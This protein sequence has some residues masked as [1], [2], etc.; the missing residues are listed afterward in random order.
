M[1]A[2][3]YRKVVYGVLIV[4]LWFPL[5]F[6]GEPPSV[7][8]E[9]ART[10]GKLTMLRDEYDLSQA[11]LGEIDPTSESMK[12]A[13]LGM[14]GVAIN[15]LWTMANE[16][17][18]K[19]DFDNFAATVNQITTLAPNFISVWEFQAH[20]ET[21]NVSVEYDAYRMRY[22]WVKKGIDLLIRGTEF[23]RK[24]TRLI[25]YLSWFF[26]HKIGTAD[27]KKQFRQLF[28]EDY[29]YHA[30]LNETLHMAMDDREVLGPNRKDPDNWLVSRKVQLRAVNLVETA[31]VPIRGKSPVLFYA[32]AP[33]RRINYSRAIEG[34]GW[35]GDVA[36]EAWR[37]SSEDWK[38]YGGLPIPTS[39]GHDVRLSEL[40][41]Y[42]E[43][44][45]QALEELDEIA[46]GEREKIFNERMAR[47]RTD[48]REALNTPPEKRTAQQEALAM[49]AEPKVRPSPDEVANRV[50]GEKR[51]EAK[52]LAQEAL[53]TETHAS[54]IERYRDIVNFAYWRDRCELEQMPEALAARQAMV[55]ADKALA[56][57]IIEATDTGKPGA[58]ELYETA[59]K[60]W[61]KVY[62]KYPHMTN[63]TEADEVV[64][65]IDR[66][67]SVLLQLEYRG[68][69]A[70]FPLQGL[71]EAQR[72]GTAILQAEESSANEKT[73]EETKPSEPNGSPETKDEPEPKQ[74]AE[75]P[76]E[77][78][79]DKKTEEA[80][81]PSE[82]PAAEKTTEKK[83]D[84]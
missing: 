15:V 50:P 45:Q 13:T 57:G 67:R 34:E 84:E 72:K 81:K 74:P 8:E 35:L 28:R 83:D 18:K 80:A 76:A 14:R 64:E 49:E 1:N 79:S 6:I 7:N 29:D 5:S 82:E 73:I 58:K 46:K 56:E 77:D 22:A 2:S 55:D 40:E 11:N 26:G 70:D 43:R 44:Q 10:G 21:Y 65:A 4:L 69:P 19:E 31:G 42:Q 27:E 48:E 68:L 17:K 36:G 20:N 9:G 39:W 37:L 24:D 52:R 3:F 32:E 38:E 66:Y 78:R 63:D 71:L 23:N 53:E 51:R 25:N 62:G 12:L 16:Y 41:R 33:M 59:W 30:K 75:A 54:R 61:A 47:L 60:Q